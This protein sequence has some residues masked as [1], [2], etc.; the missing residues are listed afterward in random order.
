MTI[1]GS[2]FNPP[3]QSFEPPILNEQLSSKLEPQIQ[4]KPGEPPGK[5]V[6]V[7]VSPEKSLDIP[8]TQ[9]GDKSISSQ[10]DTPLLLPQGALIGPAADPIVRDTGWQEEFQGMIKDLDPDLAEELA[11]PTLEETGLFK[12]SLELLARGGL[13]ADTTVTRLENSDLDVYV[14]AFPDAGFNAA[15]ETGTEVADSFEAHL[16]EEG[17]N[18]PSYDDAKEMVSAF[19]GIIGEVS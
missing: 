13:W 19:R 4:A 17:P 10:A 15:I 3:P 6:V 2:G 1:S 5:P 12:E 16:E 11:N 8:F 18:N 14:Q 9:F 7:I